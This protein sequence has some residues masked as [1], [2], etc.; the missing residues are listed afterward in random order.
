[1]KQIR[2]LVGTLA[3]LAGAAAAL[4]AQAGDN[5]GDFMVS[6]FV[7]KRLHDV[8]LR[9]QEL[10]ASSCSVV[11]PSPKSTARELTLRPE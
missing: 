9:E 10:G 7:N 3:L 11:S 1:M 4:P 2:L 8:I 6:Y 5:N